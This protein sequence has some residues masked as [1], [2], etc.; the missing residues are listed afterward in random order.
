VRS[1]RSL[2]AKRFAGCVGCVEGSSLLV[3]PLPPSL[4]IARSRF[5][6]DSNSHCLSP[7]PKFP[8]L[9][10]HSRWSRSVSSSLHSHL[11]CTI[12]PLLGLTLIHSKPG[13]RFNLIKIKHYPPTPHAPR[14]ASRGI[15]NFP[16]GPRAGSLVRFADMPWAGQLPLANRHHSR[17]LCAPSNRTD[18]F[19]LR[20]TRKPG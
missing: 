14:P 2:T 12:L 10:L 3:L 4:L 11:P 9:L 17:A 16:F 13:V 7:P 6:Q 15:A 8:A 5:L 18:A 1:S 20:T 19:E